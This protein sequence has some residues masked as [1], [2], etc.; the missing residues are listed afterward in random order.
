MFISRQS[1]NKIFKSKFWTKLNET[2]VPFQDNVKKEDFPDSL[3]DK[4]DN[5]TYNPKPPREYIVY[6]KHNGV[7]RYVPTFSR[8]DYCVYFLCVKLIEDEIAINRVEGTYGGWRLGNPIRL[9]EEE[10][11]LE[12][13]YVPFNTL[14][15]FAWVE[16]WGSFQNIARANADLEDWKYI[17]K[18]DIANFYDCVN[19]NIL[20]KKVRSVVSKEK[21]DVV[22]LLFYFLQNWNKKLEG[23]HTKTIGIPQD[24]IGDCSRILANFYLQDYDESIRS[25]CR[26]LEAKYI[27]YSDDQIL[28]AKSSTI[29]KNILFEIS[30]ELLKINLSINS[31]KINELF[32]IDDFNNYWCFD[33]FDLLSSN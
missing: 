21:Q 12:L 3:Y 31:G 11:F 16:E 32:K 23:Y 22:T 2:I 7:S 6:N 30:K 13:S 4:I 28:Y 14:N 27:R 25:I 20:E 26:E 18:L 1:F 33:L 10:E 24:E 15:S 17:T 29:A 19:L 9:K 5:F 8:E